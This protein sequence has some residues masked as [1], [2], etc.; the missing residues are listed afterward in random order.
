MFDLADFTRTAA[1]MVASNDANESAASL[2]RLVE[3][4]DAA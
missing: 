1:A 2:E 4:F 3:L